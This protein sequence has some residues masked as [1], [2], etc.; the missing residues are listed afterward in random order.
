[1]PA[2][3]MPAIINPPSAVNSKARLVE[4]AVEE[5]RQRGAR[6]VVLRVLGTNERARS[7]FERCGFE[8]EAFL[9]EEYLID[10]RYIDEVWMAR[11]VD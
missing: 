10:G 2:M 4:A 6:K 1:M 9:R 7:L 8:I 5:A 3:R 11:R